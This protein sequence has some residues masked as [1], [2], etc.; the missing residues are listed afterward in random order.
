ME[1]CGVAER[2]QQGDQGGGGEESSQRIARS[3]PQRDPG[4]D[5]GGE[6]RVERHLGR[7]PGP[8]VG[9][10]R[11]VEEE[12]RRDRGHE[13]RQ[14]QRVRHRPRVAQA[15]LG[16]HRLAGQLGHGE[17]VDGRDSR[18]DRDEQRDEPGGAREAPRRHPGR[19]EPDERIADAES[20]AHEGDLRV[21]PQA[22]QAEAQARQRDVAQRRGAGRPLQEE[23]RQGK[24]GQ[25][26][27]HVHVH[28]VADGKA[29]PRV[30]ETGH[31]GGS[32][33]EAQRSHEGGHGQARGQVGD[34][35]GRGER[36]G[37]V[38]QDEERPVRRIERRRD[39]VGH[40]RKPRA[41]LGAP[42]EAREVAGAE[43]L[44]K[45]AGD[46]VVNAADVLAPENPSSEEERGKQEEGHGTERG[47]EQEV[48]RL[49][50]GRL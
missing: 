24:K 49:Q 44:A 39:A 3:R 11:R 28:R 4:Q 21:S 13:M 14:R 20:R 10:R 48:A 27:D 47:E 26:G 2:E 50:A 35:E 6:A 15:A 32:R 8:L 7:V 23:E 37:R 33:A 43:R 45:Q 25:A 46:R 12:E 38:E 22:L 41:E 36:Q 31:G 16:T 42:E 29:A 9:A 1:R 34:E 17:V 30:D 19:P 5:E 18:A 40:Q